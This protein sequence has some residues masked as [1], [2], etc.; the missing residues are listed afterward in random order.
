MATIKEAISRVQSLYSK[1]VK[2]DDSRLSSRHIYSILKSARATLLKRKLDKRNTLSPWEIQTIPCVELIEAEA[3]ECPCVPPSGCTIYRSR[4]KIPKP[5]EAM[6]NNLLNSVTTLDGS[7]L[8]SKTTW[9]EKKYKKGRRYTG[10]SIDYWIRNEYLYVT[11]N[12]FV[13]VVA[14]D[15]PFEDPLEV[16]KFISFCNI[17]C[18]ECQDCISYLDKEFPL[19]D[20]LLQAAIEM[21][22]RELDIFFKVPEDRSNNT[23]DTEGQ[24]TK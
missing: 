14:I 2:S 24:N 16:E 21:T 18:E 7:V 19:E 8:F 12:N 5:L 1:G 11:F 15:G 20:S 22:I 4:Y 23:A 9:T 10:S 13:T 3:H 17:D 6:S